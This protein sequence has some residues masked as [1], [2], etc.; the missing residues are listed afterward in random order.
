VHQQEHFDL[1]GDTLSLASA[2][3]ASN[4]LYGTQLMM[5]DGFCHQLSQRQ[6]TREVDTIRLH[7]RSSQ[8]RIFTWDQRLLNGANPLFSGCYHMGL[9]QYR[10]GNLERAQGLFARAAAEGDHLSQR[11]QD[12]IMRLLSTPL[13]DGWDGCWNLG[14]A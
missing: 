1:S 9:Q 12:R 11:M 6:G 8:V 14:Q 2:L 13:P 5:S 10:R 4:K 3:E 7:D